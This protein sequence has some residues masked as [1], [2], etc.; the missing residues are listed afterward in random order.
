VTAA[1]RFVARVSRRS[2]VIVLASML[3]ILV[4]G[5]VNIPLRPDA[6]LAMRLIGWAVLAPVILWM[7]LS[8][9]ALFAT[10]PVIEIDERGLLWRRWS[11]TRIPWQAVERWQARAFINS[12]YVTLWLKQ[13]ERYPS[14]TIHRLLSVGNRWMGFGHVT[15]NPGG[16]DRDLAAMVEAM[17]A[18]A[19]A[20]PLSADGRS[21]SARR[22]APPSRH[23]G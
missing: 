22:T 23:P 8:L 18:H 7:L 5:A 1:G 3:P 11:S 2:Q 12:G 13:P 14:T 16:T 4:I 20:P 17:R 15:L 9:R 19:P 10:A 6:P 21:S